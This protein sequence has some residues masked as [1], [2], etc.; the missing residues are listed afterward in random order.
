M[1][2]II[3]IFSEG[4]YALIGGCAVLLMIAS[5]VLQGGIIHTAISNFLTGICG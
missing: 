5:L 3:E 4:F 1:E 2:Q